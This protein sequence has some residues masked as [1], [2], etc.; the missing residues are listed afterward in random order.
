[1]IYVCWYSGVRDLAWKIVLLLGVYAR[2]LRIHHGLRVSE[3]STP[4]VTLRC[5]RI[6]KTS[7]VYVESHQQVGEYPRLLI[8]GSGEY[9]SLPTERSA[10]ITLTREHREPVLMHEITD[11][12]YESLTVVLA[13]S[14]VTAML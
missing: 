14:R 7:L 11:F 5:A 10:V 13:E 3:N 6:H 8:L 2:V 1:M 4:Q 9:P 12:P